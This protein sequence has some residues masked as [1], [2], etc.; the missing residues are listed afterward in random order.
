MVT[1]TRVHL[2]SILNIVTD[3]FTKIGLLLETCLHCYHSVETRVKNRI[4]TGFGIL[5]SS[6]IW[7]GTKEVN[8]YVTEEY[9]TMQFFLAQAGTPLY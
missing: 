8:K 2:F 9:F 3:R 1:M 6:T 4:L 5:Y 7:W